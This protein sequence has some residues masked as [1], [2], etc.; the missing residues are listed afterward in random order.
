MKTMPE[1]T[2]GYERMAGRQG[3]EGEGLTSWWSFNQAV[4]EANQSHPI[5]VDLERL[6]QSEGEE[7]EEPKSFA[8]LLYDVA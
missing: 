5:V 2:D 6:I 8:T 4:L 3:P 7:I 1:T